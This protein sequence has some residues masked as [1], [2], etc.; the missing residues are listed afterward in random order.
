MGERDGGRFAGTS[1]SGPGDRRRLPRSSEVR[2]RLSVLPGDLRRPRPGLTDE[3]WTALALADEVH[4]VVGVGA[5]VDFP[6]G[7]P[8]LRGGNVSS[9]AVFHEVGITAIGEDDPP[10]R[11]DRL[12]AGCDQSKWA[13]EVALRRARDHG[14]VVTATRPGGLGEHTRT[15]AHDPRDLSSGLLAAFSRFRTVRPSATSTRHPWTG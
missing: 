10:A 9:V 5:A 6:R 13:A 15:G 2:R 11:V 7:Y 12:G 4:A 8:S 3:R 1:Y 14:L